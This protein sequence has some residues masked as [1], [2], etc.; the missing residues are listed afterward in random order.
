MMTMNKAKSLALDTIARLTNR[1]REE[2]LLIDELTQCRRLGWIFFYETRAYLEAGDITRALGRTGPVVVTHGGGVH[3]L[4]AE[5][6]A[7]ELLRELEGALQRRR[8][9]H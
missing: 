2:L 7:E 3:A 9:L 5:R 6:P 8:S 4:G 1:P